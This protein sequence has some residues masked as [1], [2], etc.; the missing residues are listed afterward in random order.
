MTRAGEELSVE[1]QDDGI[2]FDPAAADGDGGLAGLADRVAGP[3]RRLDVESAP[4]AG[5]R[6]RATLPAPERSHA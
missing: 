3:R 2:G 1:V 5:T 6:V 4:R